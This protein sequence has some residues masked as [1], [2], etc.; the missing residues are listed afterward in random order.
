MEHVMITVA[1]TGESTDKT[2]NRALPV[3]PREIA[4]AVYECYQAGA[5]I[6]H[7][8]MRD[9]REQPTMDTARFIDT[10]HRIRE[11]CDI[12]IN[13]TTSGDITAA[14][15]IR[16]AHLKSLQ[17]ELASFDCG[18]M[19]WNYKEIFCNE[20]EFLEELGRLMQLRSIKP[21]VEIFDT[22]M[23]DNARHYVETG[24]LCNPVHYQFV[25]GCP[26]GMQATLEN[27]IFLVGKLP[28]H[29]TWSAVGIGRYHIPILAASLLL[30]GHV[31]VGFEDNIYYKK[32]VLAASNTQLVER[33]VR[34][35]GEFGREAASPAD[36]R[37]ILSI[38]PTTVPCISPQCST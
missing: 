25:L 37:R 34:L 31:R 12:L 16:M 38:A 9:S 30:G 22:G 32:G 15:P 10:Y 33:A 26:G 4:D 5:C 36:A 2:K 11:K 7:L 23:L 24:V 3:T 1:P 28:E 35:A 19:N 20:P 18:T 8:H 17:P 13:L 14:P 6:A 27:L 29:A 21:E